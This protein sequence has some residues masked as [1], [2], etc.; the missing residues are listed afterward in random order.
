MAVV[1]GLR[2][3]HQAEPSTAIDPEHD[4]G[5]RRPLDGGGSPP[6]AQGVVAAVGACERSKYPTNMD[7]KTER[8]K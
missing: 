6:S 1:G 5:N 8:I 2:S 3:E 4:G 7:K